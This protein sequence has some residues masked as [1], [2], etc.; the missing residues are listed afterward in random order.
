MIVS[1]NFRGEHTILVAPE[2]YNEAGAKFN[3]AEYVESLAASNVTAIEFY[4]KDHHG[5]AYYATKLGKRSAA[6][7]GDYLTL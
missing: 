1:G 5:I 2:W 4:V 7:R 3:A 6:M